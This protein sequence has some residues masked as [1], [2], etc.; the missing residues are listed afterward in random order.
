[1]KELIIKTDSLTARVMIVAIVAAVCVLTYFAALWNFA[2]AIAWRLDPAAPEAAVLAPYLVE[3]SPTDPTT[4][5]FVGQYYEKSFEPGSEELALA[6]Y[7][8]SVELSPHNYIYRLALAKALSS[9]GDYDNALREFE[10][11]LELAPNNSNVQWAF[12]NFLV[13]RGRIDEGFALIGKAAAANEGFATPA[14]T[15]AL[16]IFEG[17]LNKMRSAM[18]DSQ[19][20]DAAMALQLTAAKRYDDA[21]ACWRAMSAGGMTDRVRQFGEVLAERFVG[22]RA[23]GPAAKVLGDIYGRPPARPGLVNDPGFESGVKMRDAGTFEWVIG[24]GSEP[25]ITLTETGVHQGRYS[26][27]V[28]FNSFATADFREIS[29]IV[30]VEPNTDYE[31]ELWYRSDLKTQAGYYWEAIDAN[32][33][34][35]LVRTPALANTAGWAAAKA[36]FRTG[37]A[38]DAVMLRFLRDGCV[39]PTCPT[40]GRIAFDDITIRRSKE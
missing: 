11:A 10:M 33:G 39:G 23:Y 20:L 18:A 9:A 6:A 13:R 26:L 40:V 1:M 22:M 32:N 17:D 16:Q 29:Q 3:L 31:F 19:N 7:R 15:L 28:I 38:S 25:Q 36:S 24:K 5:L 34:T 37:A 2:S 35:L 21:L 30:L 14:V 4:Q 8:R 12:G 27:L